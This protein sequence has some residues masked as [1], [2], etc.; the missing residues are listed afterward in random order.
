ML[1]QWNHPEPVIVCRSRG[2]LAFKGDAEV[3]GFL[4]EHVQNDQ[5]RICFAWKNFN[6]TRLES[7]FLKR[8]MACLGAD[9]FLTTL[10]ITLHISSRVKRAGQLPFNFHLIWNSTKG[11]TSISKKR[12]FQSKHVTSLASKPSGKSNWEVRQLV[13]HF[14]FQMH[15]HIALHICIRST[16]V[17]HTTICIIFSAQNSVHCHSKE[18]CAIKAC[19]KSAKPCGLCLNKLEVGG[20]QELLDLLGHVRADLWF[21][22]V[23]CIYVLYVHI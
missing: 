18:L 1:G 2:T 13:S 9:V 23:W 22:F 8:L 16:A 20:F 21:C 11:T 7:R 3:G 15:V 10:L 4:T 14:P 12:A 6:L 19:T 5:V 17:Q